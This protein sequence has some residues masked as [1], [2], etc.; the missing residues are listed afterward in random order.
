[1][2]VPVDSGALRD[3]LHRDRVDGRGR[4]PAR[5]AA[6]SCRDEAEM[7]MLRKPNRWSHWMMLIASGAV[8]LQAPGCTEF[9]ELAQT[10][11]LAA[12]AG[13][14]FFLARNV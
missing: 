11:L 2:L 3:R 10:G 7:R 9:L 14:T 6:G 4:M 1:V 13:T 8:L 12:L 5:P